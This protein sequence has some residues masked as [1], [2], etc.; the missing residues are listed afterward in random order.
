[1]FLNGERVIDNCKLCPGITAILDEDIPGVR[2]AL[3]SILHGKTKIA[4]HRGEQ[5]GLLR[6]HVPIVIP[7]G[8][9]CGLSV[10]GKVRNWSEEKAMVFDHSFRHF[11]WNDS[12]E[13]RVILIVDFV[14]ELRFPWSSINRLAIKTLA[15]TQYFQKVLERSRFPN[16]DND[17]RVE[18]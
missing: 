4:E 18:A 10:D 16:T 13:I 8:G 3:L 12:D 14:R 7:A 6:L 17:S 9:T 2:T 15:K 11:A 5:N 1:M